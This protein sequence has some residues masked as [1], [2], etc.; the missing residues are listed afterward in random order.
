MKV[1]LGNLDIGI[2]F[3]ASLYDVWNSL[4]VLY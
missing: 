1:F 2:Q 3:T 4:L